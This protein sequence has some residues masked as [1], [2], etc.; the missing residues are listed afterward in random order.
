MAEKTFSE[1]SNYGWGRTFNLLGKVPAVSKRIFET[2]ADAQ[3]FADDYNDSA[4]EGLLLSVVDDAKN[5]GVYFVERIKK[6]EK[7]ENAK[8]VKVGYDEIKKLEESLENKINTVSNDINNNKSEIDSYTVNNKNI[9]D[10]PV[11]N[12][13]DLIISDNYSTT[14]QVGENVVPGDIVTNAISKIEVMLANTTLAM[15]AALN[16][17]DLRIGTDTIENENGEIVAEA[18]GLTKII[19]ENERVISSALTDLDYRIITTNEALVNKSDYT[20]KHVSA[21]ITDAIN[22]GDDINTM[23]PNLVTAKAV[24][25]FATYYLANKNHNHTIDVTDLFKENGSLTN[26]TF[27]DLAQNNLYMT[28]DNGTN[29]GVKFI[30]FFDNNL[31]FSTSGVSKIYALLECEYQVTPSLSS[32][33]EFENY[34]IGEYTKK[35]LVGIKQYQVIMDGAE[36]D[37]VIM[38]LR[39]IHK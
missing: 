22:T 7:D 9:S 5:N 2:L 28:L 20:H 11:L 25:E 6:D 38:T 10:N 27:N 8:L 15:T 18:T 29:I 32:D 14:N 33:S 4:I 23:Q 1:Q 3:G 36:R 34:I 30:P 35:T 21:D 17:L 39:M 37:Y 12:S 26:V 24:N 13:D 19:N 16:D 31:G